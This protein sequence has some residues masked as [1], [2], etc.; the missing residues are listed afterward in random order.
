MLLDVSASENDR[1]IVS[2]NLDV[3]AAEVEVMNAA[4]MPKQNYTIT[5]AD[6]T[7]TGSPS[8]DFITWVN[9][10]DESRWSVK[11]DGNVIKLSYRFGTMLLLN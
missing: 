10:P 11:R 1:L 3:S 9:N 2:G 8:G 7:I 5:A 6:G 4:T